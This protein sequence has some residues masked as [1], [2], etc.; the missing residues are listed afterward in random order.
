MP[1]TRTGGQ[2]LI[3]QLKIHGVDQVFCVPGES[4]L[5][6]LDALHDSGIAVTVCRQEGGAAMMADAYGK[7][8]GRPGICFVT[9]GPGA[10]N[11]SA[12]IHIAHQDSTP[13]I[14][15]VGQVEKG[16]RERGA[17]QELDYRA[18]FGTMTKW[19]TEIDEA[20]R[21]P[22]LVSR[23]FHLAVSG[24]PGP[25]VMAL[26]EDMLTEE[27]AVGDARPYKLFQ[28]APMEADLAAL[29][30]LL[31]SARAPVIIAGGGSWSAEAAGDLVRFSEAQSIPVIASFRR[32]DL[33]PG[34]HP[35][36]AGD[37][38]PGAN[39]R[40]V[41]RVRAADLVLLLGDRFSEMPSQSYSLLKIPVPD[42][43][44]I[45]VHPDAAELGRV[46]EPALAINASPGAFLRAMVSRRGNMPA[47]REAWTKAANADYR[48]WSDEPTAVPGRF[49][50]GAALCALRRHLPPG[51]VIANGAGNYAGWVH[52]FWRFDRYGT[53]LAPGSGSMGYG[54]PAGIAAARLDP[55]RPVV[56]FAG[57]GCYLMHGQEFATAVQYEL[58]VIVI[59]V[60]NGMY[61]TIRMHQEREYPTRVIATKLKNPDFA[62]YARAFG[63][64][65]ERVETTEDFLSAFQ[66]A[67][68]SGKPAIL[69]CLVD[70]EA[71][72]PGRTLSQIRQ[73]ALARQP[74]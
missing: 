17:F 46:Y 4:Y 48:A 61:G 19:A 6:A 43:L 3:D 39:P 51:A 42:Q 67:H 52:R 73:D 7:L 62:A 41:E 24:R 1:K 14:L 56:I 32:Q 21:I 55:S 35:H 16:M 74:R 28:P 10:T 53:Q 40:L 38:G 64:H 44:L 29:E 33:F 54:V 47:E 2:I 25:I 26:P 5:A 63:G 58:P 50:F 27:A 18:V 59:I 70:P 15:F 20:A 57:D 34:S 12:G 69:H 22:E 9:R 65:G 68:D 36:C 8:T 60:D 72:T 45:H 30:N 66:R 11:A 13:L 37:L 31:G 23:A 71:L 49:N